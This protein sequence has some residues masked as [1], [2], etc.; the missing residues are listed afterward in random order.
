MNYYAT[1]NEIGDYTGFYTIEI[2]GENIPEPNIV[3]TEEQWSQAQSSRCRVINGV[4]TVIPI[5]EEEELNKKWAILRSERNNLLK[6]TD[7]IIL[8]DSPFSESK[9]QEWITYR[10]ALRDLPSVVDIN[11]VIYPEKPL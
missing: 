3:L 11:N 6:E 9:K 4:H 1:Y 10:Q 5:T 7:W 8:P 2:H